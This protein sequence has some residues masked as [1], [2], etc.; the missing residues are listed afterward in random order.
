[1]T[2]ESKP[3]EQ[4]HPKEIERIETISSTILPWTVR[5]WFGF[6]GILLLAGAFAAWEFGDMAS[7]T[8]ARAVPWLVVTALVLGA[9]AI[10]ETITLQ[11]WL[12]LIVGA[13]A[14][15]ITFLIMGRVSTYPSL[16]QSV[17][18]VDRFSGEV[19]L[20]TAQG[21]KV[22]PRMG[23]FLTGPPL[24]KLPPMHRATSNSLTACHAAR[25]G[26]Q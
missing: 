11:I 20:C 19:E 13:F 17:F 4:H 5:L 16:G 7:G 26:A 10:L 2:D 14:F 18:V 9:F 12:A 23:T 3:S 8:M 25:P 21:C 6:A 22:L 15:A 24:P 1:M